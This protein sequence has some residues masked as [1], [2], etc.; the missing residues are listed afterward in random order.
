MKSLESIMFFSYICWF[1]QNQHFYQSQQNID[2]TS[3][4]A[5][6]KL[7]IRK[8]RLIQ[9]YM[10]SRMYSVKFNETLTSMILSN[11]NSC[12]FLLVS[13]R[14][15]RFEILLAHIGRERQSSIVALYL[16]ILCFSFPKKQSELPPEQQITRNFVLSI[17]SM[18]ST[19]II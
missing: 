1:I 14:I 10:T 7:M 3:G 15:G 11:F 16:K 19:V 2:R 8:L 18:C 5:K 4:L 12:N 9:T 6:I 17:K 13:C